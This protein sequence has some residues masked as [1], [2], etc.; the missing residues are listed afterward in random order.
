M[1]HLVILF[2]IV[3]SL[4]YRNVNTDITPKM[5]KTINKELKKIWKDIAVSQ[6]PIKVKN[7]GTRNLGFDT[8]NIFMLF[9][10]KDTLGLLFVRRTKA[11]I[12]GGCHENSKKTDYYEQVG[13]FEERYEHFEY[14]AILNPDL[15]VK[16]VKVLVYEGE[17]GY[18]VTSSLW[19]KQF[20]GYKDKKLKYGSDIQALSGATVSAQSI[21]DDIQDL[22]QS[23]KQLRAM[24]VL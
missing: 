3:I 4:A 13:N 7:K 2:I 8:K 21:T 11:C 23:A 18:E 17:Y 12:I 5:Q 19:L 10:G 24:G 14:M 22:V 6:V 9:D 16:K 15:S 20:I 1:K